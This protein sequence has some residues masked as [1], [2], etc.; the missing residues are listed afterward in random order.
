MICVL[1]II[2]LVLWYRSITPSPESWSAS[3]GL[4]DQEYYGFGYE[5][6]GGDSAGTNRRRVPPTSPNSASDPRTRKCFDPHMVTV[7]TASVS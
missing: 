4:M 3:H 1:V 5:L 7:S 6:G 2:A